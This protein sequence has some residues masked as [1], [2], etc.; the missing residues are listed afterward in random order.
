MGVISVLFGIIA[1]SIF[2]ITIAYIGGRVDIIGSRII[3][4]VWFP[5]FLLSL[6]VVA[7]IGVGFRCRVRS[8]IGKYPTFARI[9]RSV[10]TTS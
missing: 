6:L 7:I 4:Y 2:G 5:S 10:K 3:D 1:G 9:I 8:R